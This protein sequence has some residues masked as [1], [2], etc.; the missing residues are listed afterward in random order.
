MCSFICV[1]ATAAAGRRHPDK[2][3][4]DR[5]ATCP[6]CCLPVSSPV[7]LPVCL[8][9]LCVLLLLLLLLLLRRAHCR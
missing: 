3:I 9:S 8:V 7:R 6:A 2:F 1:H 4:V 5:A